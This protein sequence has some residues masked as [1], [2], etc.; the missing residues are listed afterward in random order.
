MKWKYISMYTVESICRICSD[1]K[2]K[3]Q[4]GIPS[5]SVCAGKEIHITFRDFVSLLLNT[6]KSR[7]PI[8]LCKGPIKGKICT[9]LLASFWIIFDCVMIL[10][11]VQSRNQIIFD[12]PVMCCAMCKC[13]FSIFDDLESNCTLPGMK[14]SALT[15][16]SCK[17]YGN[18]WLY[19]REIIVPCSH[20]IFLIQGALIGDL[21]FRVGS[22]NF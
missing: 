16:Q 19:A 22:C 6:K 5:V 13:T 1:Q 7:K 10:W 12:Q 20:W 3:W 9:F 11:F 4:S 18:L 15:D 8:S 2:I 21:N 14:K 17:N